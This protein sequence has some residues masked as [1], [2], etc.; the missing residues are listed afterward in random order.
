MFRIPLPRILIFLIFAI[1][2]INALATHFFW[3]WRIWWFDMPMHFLGGVW[4]GG[5][6]L[7]WYYFGVRKNAPRAYSV[8][9]IVFYAVLGA[10]VIGAGWEL[11]EFIVDTLAGRTDYNILDT[12]SDL[13]FDVSGGALAGMYLVYRHQIITK[14]KTVWQK[15]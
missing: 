8:W 13:F 10:F 4:V 12:L 14:A 9:K 11:Y 2:I 1:A 15:N 3:Y 7:W 6:T 5:M